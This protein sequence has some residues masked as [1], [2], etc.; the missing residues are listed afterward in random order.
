MRRSRS[1]AAVFAGAI[2]LGTAAVAAPPAPNRAALAPTP[3]IVRADA[4]CGHGWH[5]VPPGYARHGKWRDGH[6]APN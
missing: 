2:A 3:S 1:I 4:R 6:C 5:W